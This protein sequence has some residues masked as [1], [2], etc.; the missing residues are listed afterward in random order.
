MNKYEKEREK[1][2]IINCIPAIPAIK[3]VRMKQKFD[4]LVCLCVSLSVCV[5]M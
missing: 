3:Q 5:C 2:E 1:P 4:V